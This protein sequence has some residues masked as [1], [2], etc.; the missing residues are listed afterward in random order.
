M[1]THLW[2]LTYLREIIPFQHCM[3][4]RERNESG[5]ERLAIDSPAM[6]PWYNHMG[7]CCFKPG[8]L[9]VCVMWESSCVI[10]PLHNCLMKA[11]LPQSLSITHR[12][13][14]AYSLCSCKWRDET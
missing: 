8:L 2:D 10:L 4:S 12:S 5:K 14:Q 11:L 3:F 6:S 9:R 13:Y 1:P 7:K